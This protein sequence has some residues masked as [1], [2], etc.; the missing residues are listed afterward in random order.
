MTNMTTFVVLVVSGTALARHTGALVNHMKKGV[1]VAHIDAPYIWR[2]QWRGRGL[3]FSVKR[4]QQWNA[5]FH[6]MRHLDA[7]TFYWT[8]LY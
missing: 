2:A 8:N 1:G 6:L 5:R 3:G 7:I 4:S